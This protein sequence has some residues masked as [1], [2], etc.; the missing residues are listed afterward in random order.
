VNHLSDNWPLPVSCRLL[1]TAMHELP[2]T[3][4]QS[5]TAGEGSAISPAMPGSARVINSAVGRSQGQ[6]IPDAPKQWRSVRGK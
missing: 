5:R 2:L 4:S 1:L 3:F 6:W